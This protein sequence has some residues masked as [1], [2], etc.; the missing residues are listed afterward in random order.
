MWWRCGAG[1]HESPGWRCT[2]AARAAPQGCRQWPE[3]RFGPCES[4]ARCA[5]VGYPQPVPI[6]TGKRLD[7]GQ[8]VVAGTGDGGS[9][10]AAPQPDGGGG[11]PKLGFDA[12]SNPPS[13][14]CK[15]F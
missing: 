11:G 7:A 15:Q 10:P 9:E 13:Q 3:G 8:I 5:G 14:I 6:V 12:K 4:K 2:E 1:G